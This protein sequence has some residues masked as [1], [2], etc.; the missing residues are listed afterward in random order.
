MAGIFNSSN[1]IC[2]FTLSK[3]LWKNSYSPVYHLQYFIV[4]LHL[5]ICSFINFVLLITTICGSL[6]YSYPNNTMIT[7]TT[8]WQSIKLSL[9]NAT[10]Y[11]A[12]DWLR[13]YTKK[14]DSHGNLIQH[15]EYTIVKWGTTKLIQFLRSNMDQFDTWEKDRI[16]EFV[17]KV[18]ATQNNQPTS[19]VDFASILA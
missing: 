17:T 11:L 18:N 15:N 13:H 12:S 19:S 14:F 9:S 7:P 6:L 16:T 1:C 3:I 5:L 2:T 4:S 8:Q 10:F